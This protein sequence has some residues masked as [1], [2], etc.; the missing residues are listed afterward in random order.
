[1]SYF[2]KELDAI[3]K[4]NIYR[5]RELFDSELIDFASNDYL[6]LSTNKKIFNKSCRYLTKQRYFSPK[7][8]TMVN[9]YHKIHKKLEK[10]LCDM[11]GFED[12]IIVGSGFLANIAMFESMPRNNDMLLLDENYHASGLMASKLSKGKVGVF[13][14]NDIEELE[15]LLIQY[16]NKYNKIIVAAEGVY[17][18][19]GDMANPKIYSLCNKYKCMLIVDEA[20]SS[21][22]IGKNLNG[23]F[24]YNNFEIKEN[25]IKMATFSK[26]YGSYGAYILSTKQTISYLENRAKPVI[27]STALSLFDTAYAY[28]AI[29]YI[30]KNKQKINI[31]INKIQNIVK[32]KLNIDMPALILPIEQNTN[33]ST[34]YIQQKLK[35]HKFLVG[36]IRQPTVKKPIIRII[37]KLN[38]KLMS[39]KA[40]LDIIKHTIKTKEKI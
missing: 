15:S 21:G 17:S 6:G 36:A 23:W 14:H 11:N 5:K 9:G 29:R 3:K 35:K 1:M 38:I 4:A 2:D 31:K 16:H 7:A 26:A 37:P 8:S 24:D 28:F 27:Y 22:V 30:K 32:E 10:L 34:K 33:K 18:M 39:F 13:K 12:G 25:H 20:H 19:S 40:I